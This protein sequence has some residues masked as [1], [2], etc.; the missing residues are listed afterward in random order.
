MPKRILI[1]DDNAAIRRLLRAFLGSQ[2]GFEVCGEADDG[3]DGIAKAR[4]LFPDLVVLDLSMPRMNGLEAAAALR[5]IVP[6]VPLI[7]FTLHRD[8]I[9]SST[10]RGLG[11]ASVVSKT[12][13][14]EVLFKE[15][16]R[17]LSAA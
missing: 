5:Q 13:K 7:L 15:V 3:V 16:Q 17:L 12:E 11:I 10:A 14:I 1:V 8:S 9:S 4:E 6:N 2:F